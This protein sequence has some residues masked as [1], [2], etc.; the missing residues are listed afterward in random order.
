[1]ILQ[2]AIASGAAD[3]TRLSFKELFDCTI[4]DT[5]C[6]ALRTPMPVTA[7]FGN[8]LKL[9]ANRQHF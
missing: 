9:A 5:S 1:M 2:R 4:F 8:R 6:S 3:R 7:R